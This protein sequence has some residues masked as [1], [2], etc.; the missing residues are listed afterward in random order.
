MQLSS[1]V[2]SFI[3]LFPL[4]H[5]TST[6]SKITTV[7]IEAYGELQ[8]MLSKG[9]VNELIEWR[10][11]WIKAIWLG[12]SSPDIGTI[13]CDC[14]YGCLCWMGHRCLINFSRCHCHH[15][16]H[17]HQECLVLLFSNGSI[18][19]TA[20]CPSLWWLFKVLGVPANWNQ[21]SNNSRLHVPGTGL[22][23]LKATFCLILGRSL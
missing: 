6:V 1:I 2:H 14:L 17:R 4:D 21:A 5:I 3:C 9:L 19:I 16:H 7:R 8:C 13:A 15:H 20:W 22:C 10:N 23:A 11:K 12:A 18:T